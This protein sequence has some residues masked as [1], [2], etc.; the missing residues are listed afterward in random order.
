M[1][2]GELLAKFGLDAKSFNAGIKEVIKGVEKASMKMKDGAKIAKKYNA[3]ITAIGASGAVYTAKKLADMVM[4]GETLNRKMITATGS[5]EDAKEAWKFLG[6]EADRLSMDIETL[7]EGYA[8]YASSVEEG[9]MSTEDLQKIFTAVTQKAR[10]T[11]MTNQEVF[12]SFKAI[13]DMLSGTTIRSQD[14]YTQLAQAMPGAAATMARALGITTKELKEL[15]ATGTLA[16]ED[17]LPLFAEQLMK[18][19]EPALEGVGESLGG[20]VTTLKNAVFELK[21]ILSEGALQKTLIAL[22]KLLTLAVKAM[23]S[24]GK[25]MKGSLNQGLLFE[26]AMKKTAEAV[27]DVT[28][29][30]VNAVEDLNDVVEDPASNPFSLAAAQAQKDLEAWNKTVVSTMGSTLGEFTSFVTGLATGADVSVG[31]MLKNMAGKLL[32][33]ATEMLV[34]KPILEWF[35]NW[36]AGVSGLSG[37]NAI[38]GIGG[39]LMGAFGHK[40]PVKAMAGG[41]VISEPVLG[42]GAN[43]HTG[44]LLGEAGPETV[45]PGG[46]GATNVTVNISAVDSQSLTQ[47]MQRNPQAI[48]GP[49][50]SALRSG[51]RGLS[52]S[53]RSAVL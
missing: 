16:S 41:G 38:G 29:T 5:A 12:S 34:I 2:V 47:L 21:G 1:I 51:D 44:Y 27:E 8:S 6:D 19:T 40:A 36:L 33:F 20:A 46:G 25:A 32:E 11:K 39:M 9:A 30:V 4:S 31:Q 52:S 26:P 24:F 3:A 17:V 53:L 43:S 10:V 48:T 15:V 23:S 45:T 13:R 18:E 37:G 50:V 35:Q 14:L 49:I 22:T 7:A 28:E 42:I